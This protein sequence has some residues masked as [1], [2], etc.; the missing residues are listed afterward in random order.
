MPKVSVI[1]PTHNRERYLRRAIQSVLEQSF[2]DFEIIIVDDASSDDTPQMVQTIGEP[3]IRYFRH[4]NNRGEAGSRNTGVQNAVGEYIAFLDDD[5]AW[6]PQKLARQ[7]YLLDNTPLQVGAVYTSF[8]M[9]DWETARVLGKWKAEKR[10]NIYSD[11]SEQN[12]IGIPST[13]L[14]RRQCFEKVGLFDETVEFGLDYDMWVRVA[15]LYEFEIVEEP[16]VHR[17]LNHERLSKNHELVLKGA[18]SKLRKYAEYFS[19]NRKA[20]SRRLLAMGVY[21]C[22]AGRLRT[23]RATFL[24]AIQLHPLEPRNYYNLALSFLGTA[25]FKKV[26]QFR[27]RIAFWQQ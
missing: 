22:Y 8:L 17:A 18:E 7:V 21:Y 11:L 10:G 13:V 25:N 20:Y 6:L 9:I 2:Q 15:R 14:L 1:I 3:R 24:K 19:L 26:K 16:M 4:D 27:D 5:D 23:G 12:W